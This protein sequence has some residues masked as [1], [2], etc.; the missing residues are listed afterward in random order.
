MVLV[1]AAVIEGD[2]LWA[3]S[4]DFK[5]RSV[6]AEYMRWLTDRHDLQVDTYEELWRW[7]VADLEAFWASIVNFFEVELSKP[8]QR[9]LEDRSMPGTRWFGGAEIN[10]AQN[11]FRHAA[12]DRPALV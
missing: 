6:M 5:E 4:E 3:P 12:A 9:I 1:S 10:Y 11:V 8:P 2:L 7:S